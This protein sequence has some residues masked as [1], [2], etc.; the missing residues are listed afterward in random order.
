[1][2]EGIEWRPTGNATEA[3]IRW[4]HPEHRV[5][6]HAHGDPRNRPIWTPKGARLSTPMGWAWTSTLATRPGH[7]RTVV[8]SKRGVAVAVARVL[9]PVSQAIFITKTG[10]TDYLY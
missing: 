5:L 1:M 2:T 8:R 10:P 4:H 9:Q 3:L 7:R 6:A